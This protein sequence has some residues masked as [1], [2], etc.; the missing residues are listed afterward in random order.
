MK[1]GWRLQHCGIDGDTI[2]YDVRCTCNYIY[3]RATRCVH[4]KRINLF[5]LIF[6]D[7]CTDCTCWTSNLS[8]SGD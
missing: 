7:A 4:C 2:I 5:I 3:M 8:P 6:T 1:I